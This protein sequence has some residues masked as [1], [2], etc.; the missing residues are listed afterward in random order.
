MAFDPQ[1][2]KDL[3]CY[4]TRDMLPQCTTWLAFHKNLFLKQYMKDFIELFAPHISQKE[5]VRYL[6]SEHTSSRE[7]INR[8][9]DKVSEVSDFR[10]V[11]SA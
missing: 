8:F 11:A 10:R 3:I 9:E 5:L 4:S 1:L 2:D 6:Y 7:I